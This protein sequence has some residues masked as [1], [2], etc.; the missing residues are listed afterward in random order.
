MKVTKILDNE[1][2]KLK[3]KRIK[4]MDSSEGYFLKENE[5]G[6]IRMAIIGSTEPFTD[7]Q[8]D[9]VNIAQSL[10]SLDKLKLIIA[11]TLDDRGTVDSIKNL[12]SISD[13]EGAILS[14]GYS[15]E[16]LY[17]VFKRY[18]TLSDSN[19]VTPVTEGIL[20]RLSNTYNKVYGRLKK[21]EEFSKGDY[22]VYAADGLK[23]V[24]TDKPTDPEAPR[25]YTK[26][27]FDLN[28]PMPI[29]RINFA[30]SISPDHKTA[31]F[32]LKVP[33][34]YTGKEKITGFSPEIVKMFKG[35]KYFT[36]NIITTTAAGEPAKLRR[37]HFLVEPRSMKPVT[38]EATTTKPQPKIPET[39]KK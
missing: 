16:D 28:E 20:S 39:P 29:D 31:K 30:V 23:Q 27:M 13:I 26:T 37:G 12:N 21:A 3:L 19:C 7:I 38:P 2:N 6:T 10:S 22:G 17:M 8:P 36:G 24:A 15:F 33:V 18:F 11:D 4:L 9:Q 35:G 1:F 14:N 34:D 32:T 5:D 25:M